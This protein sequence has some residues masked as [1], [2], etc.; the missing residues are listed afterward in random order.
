MLVFAGVFGAGS[1][2]RPMDQSAAVRTQL[3]DQRVAENATRCDI[4]GNIISK[5][6]R[7]YHLPGQRYYDETRI[8]G[9]KGERYFCSKAEARAAG[10]RRSKV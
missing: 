5:G 1:S 9:R 8:S 3:V 4:K 10:W 2:D 7:I 6:E